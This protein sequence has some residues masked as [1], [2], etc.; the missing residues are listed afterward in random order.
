MVTNSM[1]Q[2]ESPSR[3]A[4]IQQALPNTLADACAREELDQIE[5]LRRGDE[6][7]FLELV[8]RYHTS[9]V[10]VA[11]SYVGTRAVA[12]EV[13]QDAWIGVLQGISRFEGR[14]SLKT[15]IFHILV[16]RAKTRAQRERRS[17]SFSAL[18]SVDDEFADVAVEPDRFLPADH[19]QWPGHWASAPVSWEDVPE[20]RLLSQE[21]RVRIRQA[22]D[23][24]PAN[25]RTVITLRD[26]EGWT[27]EEVCNY[28]GLTETNQRVLLHRARS[29][30]R[31]ALEQYF[32]ED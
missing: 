6:R 30:A 11:A 20:E 14:S 13:A 24:M 15:W 25:Q 1:R 4:T 10:H 16:N 22:I 31:R 18:T 2:Q 3:P 28:L 29:R 23:A 32:Q 12:E 17:V 5:A 19:E 9:M 27:A 7:A 26:I 21:T 8:E